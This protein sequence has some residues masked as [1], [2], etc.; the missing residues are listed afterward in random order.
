MTSTRQWQDK[1]GSYQL[2]CREN[3]IEAKVVGSIDEDITARFTKDITALAISF[4]GRPFGYLADLRASEGY[5][6]FAL[7]DIIR[8][9]KSCLELGCVIDAL[10]ISSPLVKSQMQTINDAL[11]IPIP[12]EVRIF[13]DHNA[14]VAFIQKIIRKAAD[15]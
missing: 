6:E 7:R 4:S 15:A 8:G 14:A 13:D 3:Y 12:L 2:V 5:T 9:Y 10:M 1:Y 11:D